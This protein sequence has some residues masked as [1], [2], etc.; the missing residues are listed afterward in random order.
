LKYHV[1][2]A[3]PAPSSSTTETIIS[4]A[5]PRLAFGSTPFSPGLRDACV[6]PF[7]LL[8]MADPVQKVYSMEWH[9][10]VGH[11]AA[12]PRTEGEKRV[13]STGS[14]EMAGVRRQAGNVRPRAG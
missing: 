1:A 9:Y 13:I 10:R 3:P 6:S 7:V 11:G 5:L 14:D 2:A 8:A 12:M 4:I